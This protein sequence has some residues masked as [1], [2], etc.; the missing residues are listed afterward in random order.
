[1]AQAGY[2]SESC[3][4]TGDNLHSQAA[5]GRCTGTAGYISNA[6]INEIIAAGRDN[7][8]YIK[9]GSNIIVYDD[10]EWVA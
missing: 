5:K 4:F 2:D 8:R 9:E 3:L 10:T 7:K 1:M 6:E